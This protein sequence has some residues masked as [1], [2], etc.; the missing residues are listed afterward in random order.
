[1]ST[2]L[3]NAT[4]NGNLATVE[5]CLKQGADPSADHN[6]AIRL[7][8]ARGHVAVVERLLQDPRVVTKL[9]QNG[10]IDQYLQYGPNFPAVVDYIKQHKLYQY[11]QYLPPNLQ[12][13]FQPNLTQAS[14]DGIFD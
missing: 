3:I 14:Q 2:T 5:V 13:Q 7:A 1:M 12:P 9:L 6:L 10:E 4:K 8:S 11:I